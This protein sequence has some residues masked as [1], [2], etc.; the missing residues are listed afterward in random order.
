M[1]MLFQHLSSPLW[2]RNRGTNILDGGAPFY[3][4]YKTKDERY[5]AVYFPP[6]EGIKSSGALE[7]R[8]YAALLK[9]LELEANNI[10]DRIDQSNWGE[11]RDLFT[12][13]FL[14]K[15]R[16]EWESVFDGTD[17]CVTPIV[18]LSV[19]DNRP[20]AT[21]SESPALEATIMN[22]EMLKAGSGTNEIMNEWVGWRAGKDY[23]IDI[24]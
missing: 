21:L 5:M 9:G 3:D 22:V 12:K 2:T 6:E 1:P 4:T 19:A 8:F 15:S 17:S 7:P 24:K 14:E 20:L 16:S 18:P 11:L 10:P 23:T 13:K